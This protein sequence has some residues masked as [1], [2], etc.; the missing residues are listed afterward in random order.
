VAEAT[1]RL[2][3]ELHPWVRD[4][5]FA[6]VVASADWTLN[7]PALCFECGGPQP[8]IPDS[9]V[10]PAL[11]QERLCI[12]LWQTDTVTFFDI[13]HSA[14]R[15]FTEGYFPPEER[16]TD[17]WCVIQRYGYARHGAFFITMEEEVDPRPVVR[18][19]RTILKTP[20]GF[21]PDPQGLLVEGRV[22][23][24]VIMEFPDYKETR[25]VPL[26]TSISALTAIA[27]QDY[28]NTI[29]GRP[30]V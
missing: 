22:L 26:D 30:K 21:V 28:L 14:D 3:P 23:E 11:L 24:R 15:T 7:H 6:N 10:M 2:S 1:E 20:I 9:I 8:F 29:Y 13:E 19:L 5:M 17:Q 12:A 18:T 27:S 16:S 25:P 4:D